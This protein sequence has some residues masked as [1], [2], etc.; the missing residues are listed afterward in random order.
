M[1]TAKKQKQDAEKLFQQRFGEDV[2]ILRSKYR[3]LYGENEKYF[4]DLV[5]IVKNAFADRKASLREL[6]LERLENPGWFLSQDVIGTS[7]YTDLFADNLK[8][9]SEKIDYLKELGINYL[10]FMPLLKTREGKD[11][12]GYAVSSYIEINPKLGNMDEFEALNDQLKKDNMVT[13]IDFVLNHTA[14]EHEWAM[15]ARAGEKEYQDMYF[16]YDS[17]D[18]PAEFEKA[19]PD[20]FPELAPGNFTYY[21]DIKKWV[22]T[23]FYEF[24]WDLNYKNPFTLNCVIKDLLVLLNKGVDVV[25]MDAVRH[26]WKEVGTDCSSLPQCYIIVD[27]LKT[28]VHM[29]S[30][31][32]IFL[33]EAITSSHDVLKFFGTTYSGCQSMYNVG[34]MGALWNT[35]ATRDVRYMSNCIANGPEL[36][37]GVCWNNYIRC[38]DDIGYVLEKPEIERLGFN[39][40][41]HEQ[42]LIYYYKGDH[43]GS[44]SRGELYSYDEKTKSARI[45]GTLASLCGLEK[46]LYEGDKLQAEYSTRRIILMFASMLAYEGIPIIYIGD[47]IATLNDY[48]YKNDVEKEVDSRWLHRPKFDWERA[49]KR[50]NMTTYEGQ[51][52]QSLKTLIHTRKQDSIFHA[53]VHT[54][55]FDTWN[56]GV[57]GTFKKKD[58]DGFVF[59]A[60]FTEHYQEVYTAAVKNVGF[61]GTMYEIL[62]NKELD[63]NTEKISLKPYE[64]LWLKVKK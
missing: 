34:L 36:P 41:W 37:L 23:T 48:S 39:P 9:V 31:G 14:K 51:V 64:F 63:L 16:M 30:P 62:Q 17:Y 53:D 25:R 6:D 1:K 35:L 58:D 44:F 52:F 61:N 59:I 49:N 10:H 5:E 27:I 55:V 2:E 38:H 26:I 24:Q 13:C 3:D 45:S 40:F 21:E 43:P 7:F 12:G 15:R 54:R 46:S 47:E 60:N 18:I 50:Y 28:I 4:N 32:V 20:I 19:L 33:G 8:G 22:F 29:V 42:F 56:H 11:D 57:F